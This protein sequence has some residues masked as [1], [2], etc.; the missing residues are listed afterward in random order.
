MSL[1]S[2]PS[3]IPDGQARQC[4]IML[5]DFS[6]PLCVAVRPLTHAAPKSQ[7][8]PPCIQKTWWPRD[9]NS[10]RSSRRVRIFSAF[11]LSLDWE[12]CPHSRQSRSS[13]VAPFGLS[14]STG[15]KKARPS[16]HRIISDRCEETSHA[17]ARVRRRLT[18]L[19]PSRRGI[20]KAME[21]LRR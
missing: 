16:L 15:N 8:A 10:P 3:A 20:E 18:L 5:S 4:V 19:P 2:G 13:S 21:E 6:L 9:L 12:Q 7:S 11:F 17:S 1:T 14:A